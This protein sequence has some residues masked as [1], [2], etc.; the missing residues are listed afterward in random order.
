MSKTRRTQARHRATCVSQVSRESPS[1]IVPQS[2]GLSQKIPGQASGDD[3]ILQVPPGI[4][5]PQNQSPDQCE[6]K[7]QKHFREIRFN[8]LSDKRSNVVYFRMLL[9]VGIIPNERDRSDLH[10]ALSEQFLVEHAGHP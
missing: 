1:R 5:E 9:H 6:R 10:Q 4:Q 8:E 7:S 2:D 3:C